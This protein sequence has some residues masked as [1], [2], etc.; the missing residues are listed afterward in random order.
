[1]ALRLFRGGTADDKA[2][3]ARNFFLIWS[4]FIFSISE[5]YEKGGSSK[6]ASLLKRKQNSLDFYENLVNFSS[7]EEE[8]PKSNK[9]HQIDENDQKSLCEFSI[10]EQNENN[11]LTELTYIGIV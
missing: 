10:S 7:E 8:D 3:L 9:I 5:I 11:K 1:M 4:A 6:K 2:I